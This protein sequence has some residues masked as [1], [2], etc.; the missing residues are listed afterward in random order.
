MICKDCHVN[1]RSDV[2][3]ELQ[4]LR[5]Y[6]KVEVYF[7]TGRA[8]TGSRKGMLC[9]LQDAFAVPVGKRGLL[10]PRK[11][12][13]SMKPTD[14]RTLQQKLRAELLKMSAWMR[15]TFAFVPRTY[16]GTCAGMPGFVASKK[17]ERLNEA[18]KCTDIAR[19]AQ[20]G[21]AEDER[22]DALHFCFCSPYVCQHPC[23][24]AGVCCLQER[25]ATQ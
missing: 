5:N 24:H 1:Q 8:P 4:A 22:T 18:V 11:L 9:V 16:V 14:A 3:D 6:R 25:R 20:G 7:G 15:H 13:D 23:R 17:G 10:P 12:S 2:T 21:I 19:K